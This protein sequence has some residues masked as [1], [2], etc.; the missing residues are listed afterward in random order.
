MSTEL[1]KQLKRLGL[2]TSYKSIN[3]LRK[4]SQGNGYVLNEGNELIGLAITNKHI[5]GKFTVYSNFNKLQYLNISG[6]LGLTEVVFESGAEMNDL[7]HLDLSHNGLTSIQLPENGFPKLKY[8]DVSNNKLEHLQLIGDYLSLYFLNLSANNLKWIEF[9]NKLISLQYVYASNNKLKGYNLT[10]SGIIRQSLE[11]SA[12]F[13]LPVLP[14]IKEIDLKNNQIQKIQFSNDCPKLERLDIRDNPLVEIE[15]MEPLFVAENRFYIYLSEDVLKRNNIFVDNYDEDILW[16]A[17]NKF[18]I[19]FQE[20][21]KKRVKLPVKVLMLGN[22]SSGKSHLTQLLIK[23]E[24]S[25]KEHEI[26]STHI[27]KIEEYKTVLNDEEE[28]IAT[29]YDFGGQDFYHG[30]YRIFMDSSCMY[31]FVWRYDKNI[32][33]FTKEELASNEPPKDI[34]NYP[35]AFWLEQIKYIEGVDDG[36]IKKRTILTQSRIDETGRKF[37]GL[38]NKE[39]DDYHIIDSVGLMLDPQSEEDN[40]KYK[41]RFDFFKSLLDKTILA[42]RSTTFSSIYN[43]VNYFKNLKDNESDKLHVD[44]PRIKGD[45]HKYKE[46]FFYRLGTK[47]KDKQL[48]EDLVNLHRTGFILYF[49]NKRNIQE[50]V[51]FAPEKVLNVLRD[52]FLK[53]HVNNGI[54]KYEE[55]KDLKIDKNLM[56]LFEEMNL[57]LAHKPDKKAKYP[58]EYIIPNY[59]PIYKNDDDYELLEFGM[60]EALFYI[61]FENF[62][63]FGMMSQ[64]ITF[65]GKRPDKKRFWRNAMYFTFNLQYKVLI[66]LN[67]LTNQFSFYLIHKD[68]KDTGNNVSEKFRN[69]FFA[70][71]LNAYHNEDLSEIFKDYMEQ[72][73]YDIKAFNLE[74]FVSFETDIPGDM[75][76]SMDGENFVS[77]KELN[78]E[79]MKGRYKIVSS[80]FVDKKD[81]DNKLLKTTKVSG[82]EIPLRDFNDY[83]SIDFGRKL[84]VVIS[85]D[86][87]ERD[88][89]HKL[90][91][92]L[93]QMV[94]SKKID[95]FY[96]NDLTPGKLFRPELEKKFK[97]ADIIISLISPLWA[98][99]DFILENELP[100][101]LKRSEEAKFRH[102]PLLIKPTNYKEVK[103][104]N[105]ELKEDELKKYNFVKYNRMISASNPS[106]FNDDPYLF[107]ANKIRKVINELTN[108][109]D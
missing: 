101:A 19:R 50:K 76:I 11:N 84:R 44:I 45:I 109:A 42:I 67:L 47:T 23:G 61:R 102:I 73:N 20:E 55:F 93:G 31:C 30:L 98:N 106:E 86:R 83:S 97:N 95:I 10:K 53:K 60:G 49:P 62:I 18:F 64:I 85:Y 21:N 24:F 70:V 89:L 35:P 91:L 80:K 78:E 63:P 103:I 46:L 107:F 58:E 4:F 66:K 48:R 22:H 9:P 99:S 27:L 75:Y 29:F 43:L 17:L 92:H 39:F 79:K 40:D 26:D 51:W 13:I 37:I 87:K 96:D 65:F 57:I 34:L 33:E 5:Q 54:I 105:Y 69:F 25:G 77:V 52:K 16:G 15:G 56:A 90:L 14:I 108:K 94:R 41:F 28:H 36:S 71:V 7:T 8:F 32:K 12:P 81:G 74:N 3:E 68:N 82:K 2:E 72:E 100:I 1:K 59:L 6:N 88:E 104:E 38:T